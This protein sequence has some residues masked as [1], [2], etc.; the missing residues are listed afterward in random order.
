MIQIFTTQLTG[1]LKQL[2]EK[3]ESFED[4]GRLLA[5]ALIGEG[6]I[7][8]H[9]FHEMTA[10]QSEALLGVETFSSVAP[11]VLSNGKIAEVTA[12]DR[13]MLFTRYSDDAEAVTVA[14]TLADQGVEMVGISTVKECEGTSLT[15]V[16]DVHIDLGATLSLVPGEDGNRY[17]YPGTLLALFAYQCLY[18]STLDILTEY[19]LY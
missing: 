7:Y 16:V 6:T 10:V 19:D 12:A 9:G 11:L 1:L 2:K 14:K 15:S 17:G 4:G 5:Q 18:L 13:V 8:I 3:E